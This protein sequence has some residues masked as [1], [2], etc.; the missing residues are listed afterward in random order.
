MQGVVAGYTGK[1]KSFFT[2]SLRKWAYH[3]YD[4]GTGLAD[5]KTTHG[6]AAKAAGG[7]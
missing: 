4:D 2:G 1:G 6:V 7:C 3:R 5:S